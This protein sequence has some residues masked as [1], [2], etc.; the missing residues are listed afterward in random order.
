M[1]ITLS[2]R[3]SSVPGL[4]FW[5]R[6]EKNEKRKQKEN[7]GTVQ[8]QQC[9][10]LACVFV[11]SA[12]CCLERS[13]HLQNIH[14]THSLRIAGVPSA[15]F[16]PACNAIVR[17]RVTMIEHESSPA[18]PSAPERIRAH[19][20]TNSSTLKPPVKRL[21]SVHKVT[22]F[23]GALEKSHCDA[24]FLWGGFGITHRSGVFVDITCTGLISGR[25][26]HTVSVKR[27]PSRTDGR[28]GGLQRHQ[29]NPFNL[30]GH[31]P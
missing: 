23:K 20:R 1:E 29:S 11:W 26:R 30:G 4:S 31:R 19:P 13:S 10:S 2:A 3:H 28:V 6:E 25:K 18:H 12:V 27:A 14:G 21:P 17:K 8:Q 5:G 15:I 9:I 16:F 7:E 24:F 22:L